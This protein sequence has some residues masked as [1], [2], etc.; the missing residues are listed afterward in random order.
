MADALSRFYRILRRLS[1][2][3]RIAVYMK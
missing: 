1:G 3:L 2:N